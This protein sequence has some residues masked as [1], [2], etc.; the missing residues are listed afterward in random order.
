LTTHFWQIFKSA[1]IIRTALFLAIMCINGDSKHKFF[2]R[3]VIAKIFNY[4]ND[5]KK[6][7]D[8]YHHLTFET[9]ISL[10]LTIMKLFSVLG[11]D[12]Y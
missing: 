4:C 7:A 5:A 6:L 1:F 9:I 12:Y 2:L 3:L 11:I 8:I 10:S